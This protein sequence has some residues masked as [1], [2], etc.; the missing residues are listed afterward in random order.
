MAAPLSLL[1][2]LLLELLLLELLL[3][4]LLLLELLL[5]SISQLKSVVPPALSDSQE[6]LLH[7]ELKSHLS[8][9][10]TVLVEFPSTIQEIP[11]A[12]VEERVRVSLATLIE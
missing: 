11:P 6:N 12:V 2:L 1:E 9:K 5:S 4:E 3:L 8:K 7:P 10:R